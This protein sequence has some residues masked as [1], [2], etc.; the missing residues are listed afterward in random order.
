MSKCE[1]IACFSKLKPAINCIIT[2]LQLL[3]YMSRRIRSAFAILPAYGQFFVASLHNPRSALFTRR[4]KS[5]VRRKAPAAQRL[6]E[7]TAA[8]KT[9]CARAA[10]PGY[11]GKRR[12]NYLDLPC[13]FRTVMAWAAFALSLLL[14]SLMRLELLSVSR[15]DSASWT[16]WAAS[17]SPAG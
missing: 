4:A 3:C 8:D 6:M 5:N 14:L 7:R 17:C 16:T 11:R 2:A 12:R 13:P 9:A 10:S 15:R 1:R